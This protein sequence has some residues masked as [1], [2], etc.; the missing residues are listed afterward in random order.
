LE[1]RCGGD[2]GIKNS[3]EKAV[4]RNVARVFRKRR[5]KQKRKPDKLQDIDVQVIR[6][7][8]VLK[9]PQAEIAAYF[10]VTQQLISAIYNRSKRVDV[11]YDPNVDISKFL[12]RK[13]M[14]KRGEVFTLLGLGPMTHGFVRRI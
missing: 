11:P 1:L 4:M 9:H 8:C 3:R 12:K 14:L 13:P 5:Q 7:L 6:R 10:S 2:G